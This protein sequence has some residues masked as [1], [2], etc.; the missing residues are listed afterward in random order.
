MNCSDTRAPTSR[1]GEAASP[2]ERLS[3]TDKSLLE[4]ITLIIDSPPKEISPWV[5]EAGQ[6]LVIVVQNTAFNLHSTQAHRKSVNCIVTLCGHVRTCTVV[7]GHTRSCHGKVSVP[8]YRPTTDS[9]QMQWIKSSASYAYSLIPV[10][11]Q[12]SACGRGNEVR[13]FHDYLAWGTTSSHAHM[14]F[15]YFKPFVYLVF[16]PDVGRLMYKVWTVVVSALLIICYNCR[17]IYFIDCR[18]AARPSSA[19]PFYNLTLIIDCSL[20]PRIIVV[21]S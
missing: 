4:K 1:T 20:P 12:L 13:I 15:L 9:W 2:C 3:L 16:S 10:S 18:R 17:G 8:W 5:S 6:L 7:Q 21:K 14:W 11:V 19:F